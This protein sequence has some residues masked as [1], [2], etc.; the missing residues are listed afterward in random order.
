MVPLA[1][2][3]PRWL[4]ASLLAQLAA[5]ADRADADLAWPEA[6]LLVAKELGALAWSIPTEFGGQGL[7]RVAQLQGSEQLASACLTTA[8]VLSQREAAVRWLLAA[9]EPLRQRYLPALA[10]GDA[11]ATVGLSQLT[12]SR[13]HRPPSLRA[14]LAGADYQLDGDVP[15]VTRAD[16]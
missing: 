15:W 7:D 3:A 4:E 1:E 12:T 13:Q 11:F 2:N 9:S 8:F 14:R 10:R 16:R 6:S 5:R